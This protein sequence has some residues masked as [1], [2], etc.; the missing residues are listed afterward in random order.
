MRHL[1]TSDWVDLVRG[2]VDEQGRMR[3][4]AHLASGCRKCRRT[5]EI[6]REVSALAS[7]EAKYEV[8][9]YAVYSAR[10]I[11]ALKQP[12][13]IY[14][15]PRIVGRLIYD[16]FKE[17]LPAGLRA[18]HRLTRHAL[19]E[20]ANYSL[21]LRLEHQIG[22]A[23]VS[24]VGQIADQEER[25]RALA[26][27]PVFLLS[28]NEVVAHALSNAYGEFQLDYEPRRHLRLYLQTGKRDR[29]HIEVQL[30]GLGSQG[31]ASEVPR[32]ENK[33]GMGGHTRKRKRR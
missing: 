5:M 4:E 9:R 3:A 25:D 12:E 22:T 27:L 14:F 16:S 31:E 24:L 8:P 29:K 26:N 19:Y 32:R 21:D 7:E 33:R 2:L 23:N 11:F 6:M 30:N 10:S 13:K 18:R 17:P 20:A 1:D 28:G 15:F